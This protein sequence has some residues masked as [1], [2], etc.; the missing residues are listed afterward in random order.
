MKAKNALS[1]VRAGYDR[2]F[3]NRYVLFIL[4]F[5]L[6]SQFVFVLIRKASDLPVWTWFFLLHQKLELPILLYLFWYLNILIKPSRFRALIAATPLFFSYLAF[7]IVF[8]LLDRAARLTDLEQVP[9]LIYVT[10]PF[11][12]ICASGAVVG[13]LLLLCFSLSIKRWKAI[14]FGMLPLVALVVIVEVFPHLFVNAFQH[15]LAT[16]NPEALEWS[17]AAD[18]STHGRFFMLCYYEARRCLARKKL[19]TLHNRQAYDQE[20]LELVNWLKGKVNRRNVHLVLMESFVDPTLFM[21]ATYSQSPIHPDYQKMFAGR[22]G[23]SLSPVFGGRTTEAEFEALCGVPAYNELGGV[24]Y[25]LFS[26][27]E[28][29]CL[30]GILRGAGYRAATANTTKPSTFNSYKGLRGAGFGEQYYPK[31][32]PLP[33]G[34]SLVTDTYLSL[35]GVSKN[36]GMMFDG[37][38]FAKNREFVRRALAEKNHPP[39]FNYLRAIYGHV[40][41]WLDEKKRPK[42][43]KFTS[44]DHDDYLELVV[45]QIWY[46]TQAVAEHVR[47]LTKIDPDGLIILFSD[48]LPPLSG[49][50]TYSRLRYLN[51]GQ[52][53]IHMNRILIIDRGKPQQYKTIHHYDIPRLILNALT[54]GAFGDTWQ[55]AFSEPGRSLD[56]AAGQAELHRR[57][58]RLMAHAVK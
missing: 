50:S 47:E 14:I 6:Y 45:N 30:P 41:Y 9:D 53:S 1:V 48:H 35:A 2:F 36:E 40:P 10:P 20:A 5:Y 11:Y 8:L 52:D 23:Y 42:V 43:I 34:Y 58:M 13:Y 28:A 26:G 55:G 18:I 22:M 27:S 44:K 54:D 37:D 39:L 38:L 4:F 31:E 7:D 32:Y 56:A 17:D 16:R 33:K 19:D 3:C 15:Y 21:A 12:L 51:N 57:Y 29:W 24:E 46:R 25:G 49:I